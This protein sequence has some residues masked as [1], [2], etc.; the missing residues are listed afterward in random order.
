MDA[1]SY[2]LLRINHAVDVVGA[3]RLSLRPDKTFLVQGVP[4]ASGARFVEC[5]PDHVERTRSAAVVMQD[6]AAVCR[7]VDEPHLEVRRP[8]EQ[9]VPT[10]QQRQIGRLCPWS[11][12]CRVPRRQGKKPP[13]RPIRHGLET[14][15]SWADGGS[16]TGRAVDGPGCRRTSV[17]IKHYYQFDNIDGFS[18]DSPKLNLG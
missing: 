18:Q 16:R 17:G 13:G 12:E 8:V 14:V 6:Q 9:L 7:P 11:H 15:S 10:L 2:R 5:T 1:C 3:E 4:P